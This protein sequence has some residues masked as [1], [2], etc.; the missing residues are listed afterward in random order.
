MAIAMIIPVIIGS[1]FSCV[2]YIKERLGE[3]DWMSFF[4][5]KKKVYERFIQHSTMKSAYSTTNLGSED[6]QNE[7][8]I[9]AIQL[10]LDHNGLLK[11]NR[12][13]LELR[14]IDHD[15]SK[16]NYYYWHDDDSNSNSFA[17]TLSKY[18][19]VKK[20]MTNVWLH[21]GKYP[22]EALDKGR[23]NNTNL[24]DVSLMVTETKEKLDDKNGGASSLKQSHDIKFH[25]MSEGKESIDLFIDKAY[26]WYLDQLRKLEDNTRYL[27]ELATA[28]SSSE[29]DSDSR[30]KYKR[31]QLSDEKTFE[32][33][34]FKEKDNILKL[35][36][37]FTNKT[38]K[39]AIKGY[40]HKLGLLLH[41]PP[42]TGKTS[43]IK[44]LAQKT[45]R[46]IVNVPLSR[47]TT[48]A[49]LASI[50]FDQ[51]YYV[52][53]ERV[54]V[55]LSFKDV[56]FVMEDVD[57]IS[58]IVRRRDNRLGSDLSHPKHLEMTNS[59]TLWTMLLESNDDK[60]QQLVKTLIQK[61]HRLKLAA[62]DSALLSNIAQ[63][64][65]SVPGL[66]LVGESTN[67]ELA[68][69]V[70]SE[71]VDDAQ[72]IMSQS[73]AV[74][75]F[76]GNYSNT[77][78][79]MIESDIEVDEEF[80][81]MLLGLTGDSSSTTSF[82]S[83]RKHELGN[84]YDS[85]ESLND[86]SYVASSPSYTAS[87][88]EAMNY[89][90]GPNKVEVIGEGKMVGIGPSWK[91]RRDELNLS[92]LLNVL[93]GVVDTPGRMLVLTSNHPEML[94]PALIRPGR[95][96]KK[97]LLGHLRSED[98]VCMMEHYFQTTLSQYQIK[99]LQAAVDDAP[100][101]ALTPAQV[102]QMAC[103]FEEKEDMI[104]A[105]ENKKSQYFK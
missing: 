81:N 93:D 28:T 78:N 35:V 104:K 75:E 82:V 63:K 79:R 88:I 71:A 23:E 43:L 62:K 36:D 99:R 54:P 57:A 41:G 55:K 100:T 10:Y 70:T 13:E 49:E 89:E 24:F 68:A 64:M 12:A 37:H 11:L 73:R 1:I 50:F 67:D 72:K 30:R 87:A 90:D 3:I 48:N 38:G 69:K 21:V 97:M 20:P 77:L 17:D 84:T 102:E 4:T 29:E 9:K 58:K 27:Y 80:E 45:G 26:K 6:S 44:A 51:K 98:L 33:L 66:C 91:A 16:N 96:D 94:D 76:I 59:K 52:D 85:D 83:I 18:Q 61:S 42:G 5:K 46:S 2:K 15:E 31:Y 60:C 8:L 101:V 105:I 86:S 22:C 92:G 74:D 14:Q 40:P 32:S 7:V 56:I 103:E 19:I 95:I 53:G 47:I 25:F 65:N 34:F 39:Y